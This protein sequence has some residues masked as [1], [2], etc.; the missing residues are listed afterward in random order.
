M[1]VEQEVI[2]EGAIKGDECRGALKMTGGQRQYQ[3]PPQDGE[4]QQQGSSSWHGTP[5]P[6]ERDRDQEERECRLKRSM[7]EERE[8][9]MEGQGENV[10]NRE[11]S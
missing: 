3:R 9:R 5:S 1:G 11:K 6:A 8:F 7:H 4:E 10:N 2:E